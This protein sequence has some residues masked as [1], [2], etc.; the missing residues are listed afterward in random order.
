MVVI[1]KMVG[2]Q[3]HVLPCRPCV[4]FLL[5]RGHAAVGECPEAW[6]PRGGTALVATWRTISRLR[7]FEGD[8]H[9]FLQLLDAQSQRDDSS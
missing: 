8:R 1:G 5:H 3:T 7:S 6:T 9:K 4:K 2:E